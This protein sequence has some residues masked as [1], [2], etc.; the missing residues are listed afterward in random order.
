MNTSGTPDDTLKA[1]LERAQDA[2]KA[3]DGPSERTV[4]RYKSVA[5]AGIALRLAAEFVAAIL[6]G[7]FL[8][9]WLDV[10]LKTSPL[11][12]LIMFGFGVAAGV[13]GGIRA[14]RT[15]NAELEAQMS[16]EVDADTDG[17]KSP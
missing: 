6:V 13:M 1:R 10:W 11:F 16:A 4:Q 5:G 12:L 17:T 7:L 15:F 9:Y 14:Y 2:R 3:M 8:G